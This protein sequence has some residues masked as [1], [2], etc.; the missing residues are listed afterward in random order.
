MYGANVSAYID[1]IHLQWHFFLLSKPE[2]SNHSLK[3]CEYNI[4]C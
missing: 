2:N 1:P 3:N 4:P